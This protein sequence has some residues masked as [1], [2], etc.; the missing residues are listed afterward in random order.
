M[1]N[2]GRSRVIGISIKDRAVILSAGPTADGA[3]WFEREL[4]QRGIS[5]PVNVRSRSRTSSMV[6]PAGRMGSGFL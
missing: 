2:A 1:S 5:P 4:R 6:V 3:Y